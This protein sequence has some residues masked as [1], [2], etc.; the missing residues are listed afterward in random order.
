MRL[1]AGLTMQFEQKCVLNL[2]VACA[3]CLL[4][5]E[6]IQA[7]YL[8]THGTVGKC[9]WTVNKCHGTANRTV[10]KWLKVGQRASGTAQ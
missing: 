8:V 9:Y 5:P 3:T 10:G 6:I 2:L 7:S 4:T 1:V